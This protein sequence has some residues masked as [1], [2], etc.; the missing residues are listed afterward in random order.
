[1]RSIPRTGRPG[2]IWI[3]L[4]CS[5]QGSASAFR[6]LCLREGAQDVIDI[7]EYVGIYILLG[8]RK[9]LK[10]R[11]GDAQ[12]LEA[13]GH[14]NQGIGGSELV[15]TV[16][17]VLVPDENMIINDD[18][19]HLVPL[20]CDHAHTRFVLPN[21]SSSDFLPRTLDV[22]EHRI[23]EYSN[24]MHALRREVL[25]R[26]VEGVV[27]VRSQTLEQCHPRFSCLLHI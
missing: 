8:Q 15:G 20:V 19:L 13:L 27:G 11:V 7:T 26:T 22:W 2:D 21:L 14:R 5:W 6:V 9:G 25:N 18:R 1:M 24:P 3:L 4:L 12:D 16:K 17:A 23:A 10:R